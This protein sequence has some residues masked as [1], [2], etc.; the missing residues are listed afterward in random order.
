MP[1]VKFTVALGPP[2]VTR[3]NSRSLN[4][5]NIITKTVGGSVEY[6]V[7]M[8]EQ[9][10]LYLVSGTLNNVELCTGTALPSTEAFVIGSSV[11]R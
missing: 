10:G 11:G 7:T 1:Y 5:S 2:P 4:A 3:I 8:L 6:G 9:P